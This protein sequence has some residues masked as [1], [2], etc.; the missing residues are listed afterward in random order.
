M[1]GVVLLVALGA[2]PTSTAASDVGKQPRRYHEINKDLR[3][4]MR[5]EAS[6]NSKPDRAEAIYRLTELYRELKRDPR[7]AESDTLTE[8]KNKLW[9]RLTRVKK[10]L[11]REFARGKRGKADDTANQLVAEGTTAGLSD[12][13]ALVGY[14]TG[15][16]A[17][18]LTQVSGS[19]G[20]AAIPDFG[21][22]LVALIERTIAPDFW[23]TNGGPGSI[24]YYAPLRVLVVRA[25]GEVHG[26]VGG[27]L[28]GLRAAGK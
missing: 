28:G 12:S 2:E 22:G 6:V 23:D 19:R 25:T 10:N 1:Y 11:Q 5:R 7:L 20:G 18:L 14:S 21:P 16:P 26:N 24:V 27:A 13:L 8:Y 3:H 4:W 15:G 9:G 17:S